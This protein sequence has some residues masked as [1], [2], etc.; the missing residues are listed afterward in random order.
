MLI[1]TNAIT[2][3]VVTGFEHN[4][5]GWLLQTSN[6]FIANILDKRRETASLADILA[7]S[8][9]LDTLLKGESRDLPTSISQINDALGYDLLPI[10]DDQGKVIFSS[11]AQDNIVGVPFAHG[12]T[13]YLYT[14]NG[15]PILMSA[16]TSNLVFNGRRFHILIGM[17]VAQNFIS[18][19]GVMSSGALDR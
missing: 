4:V 3:F 17:F 16:G 9:E 15:R 19:M 10:S 2:P 8:G 7:G 18:N 14:D 6:F 5:D 11:R 13:V 12:Q 1:A